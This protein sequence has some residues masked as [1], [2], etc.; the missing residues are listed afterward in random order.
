MVVLRDLAPAPS[1]FRGH[2][3][4][5]GSSRYCLVGFLARVLGAHVRD[6]GPLPGFRSCSLSGSRRGSLRA[7]LHAHP[8]SAYWQRCW[9]LFVVRVL[10]RSLSSAMFF[11]CPVAERRTDLGADGSISRVLELLQNLV[12]RFA[13]DAC[14]GSRILLLA[15]PSDQ[16]A[17]R[18]PGRVQQPRRSSI[19]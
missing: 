18:R 17:V 3:R 16:R 12:R 6:R 10:G 11:G 5:R 9:A 13:A 4:A 8:A 2:A 15:E 19:A 14:N 7:M 1:P